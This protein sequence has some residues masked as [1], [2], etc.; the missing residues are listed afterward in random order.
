MIPALNW[1]T[2]FV[3]GGASSGK[4]NIAEQLAESTGRELVY[5]AT[6]EPRDLEMSEKIA[7]HQSRR[8][9]AWRTIEAPLRTDEAIRALKSHECALLDCLTM[10]LSNHMH[11]GSDLE[12]EEIKLLNGL[13]FP[14]CPV[15]AVSNEVGCG[16][17]PN[18]PLSREF[19]ERQGRLNQKA[20]AQADIASAVISGIPIPLRG[21]PAIWKTL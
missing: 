7:L 21:D 18:N 20:A 16:I 6:A 13:T 10:W 8:S 2:A 1:V 11:A 5:I 17:I 15:I 4:T 14:P 12:T 19:N 9:K 3:V